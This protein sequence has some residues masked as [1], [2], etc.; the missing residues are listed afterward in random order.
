RVVDS[1]Q[2]PGGEPDAGKLAEIADRCIK[3]N[4]RVIATEP[5]YPAAAAEKVRD[6]LRKNKNYDVKLVEFDPIETADPAKL[7]D[8]ATSL[9]KDYYLTTMRRNI[10]NLAKS[11]P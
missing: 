8:G 4:V 10:E 9:D 7:M 11:L 6:Y 1:I 3:E 5:Q 2:L